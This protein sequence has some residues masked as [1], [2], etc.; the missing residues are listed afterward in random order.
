MRKPQ[1]TE[2]VIGSAVEVE[3]CYESHAR[4]EIAMSG[5]GD[6]QN[7]V[8]NT[9]GPDFNFQIDRPHAGKDEHVDLTVRI[10]SMGADKVEI[11]FNGNVIG[12]STNIGLT[13]LNW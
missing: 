5:I 12:G 13:K 6:F 4:K 8:N 3:A 2:G 11:D 9:L 10:P 1:P 7:K